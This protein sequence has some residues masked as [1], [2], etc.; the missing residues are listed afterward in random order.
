MDKLCKALLKG[1]RKAGQES[2]E[3][4]SPMSLQDELQ[5]KQDML[6]DKADTVGN[7]DST[8]LMDMP[9]IKNF[10]DEKD[11]GDLSGQ[12]TTARPSST[13]QGSS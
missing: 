7:I 8:D 10:L 12:P 13:S 11:L 2:G 9:E 6:S 5:K 3:A 1:M 4:T